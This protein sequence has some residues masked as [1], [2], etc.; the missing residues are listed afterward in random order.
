MFPNLKTSLAPMVLRLGLASIFLYH[1]FLEITFRGSAGWSPEL[2]VWFQKL[3]SW[4]NIVGGFALI[5]GALTRAWALWFIAIMMG[6]IITVNGAQQFVHVVHYTLH[7]ES[8]Y[9]WEAGYEYNFAIIVICLAL[10]VLGSGRWSV[11][12]LIFHRR[13]AT[14]APAATPQV[15]AA[16]KLA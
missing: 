1:G 6:A 3:V 16:D 8:P 9:R 10:V 5:L 7:R 11:D 14:A 2:P 13:K 15:N 12:F 4:G